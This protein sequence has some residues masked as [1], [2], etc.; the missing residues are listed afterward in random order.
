MG[1]NED[2]ESGIRGD[3]RRGTALQRRQDSSDM[4]GGRKEAI[5]S[6]VCILIAVG[7]RS[8]KK[9]VA[10]EEQ[11]TTLLVSIIPPGKVMLTS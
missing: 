8:S 4:L 7:F 11:N 1:R 5:D 6:L 3:D 2:A 9:P 10:I